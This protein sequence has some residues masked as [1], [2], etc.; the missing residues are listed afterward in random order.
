MKCTAIA[1]AFFA[2]DPHELRPAC[3][4]DCP[5]QPLV[6]DHSCDVQVLDMDHLILANQPKCRLVVMIA[7]SPA[8]L[9]MLDGEFAPRLVPVDRSFLSAGLLPLQ[10]RELA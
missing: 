8:N 9:A 4:A 7:A 6:P 5:R 10:S 2:H 1:I 3:V